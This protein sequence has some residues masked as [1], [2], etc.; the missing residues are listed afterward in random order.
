M[1]DS[2]TVNH[3]LQIKYCGETHW[4]YRRQAKCVKRHFQPGLSYRK[5]ATGRVSAGSEC[6]LEPCTPFSPMFRLWILSPST[7]V[8]HFSSTIPKFA[9]PTT[10]AALKWTP[11]SIRTGL[12]AR[13]TSMYDDN[14]VRV[15]VTIL[16]VRFV[17]F[18][19]DSLMSERFFVTVG[20][21]PSHSKH[22]NG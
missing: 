14:G 7:R 11:N 8:R 16:Q 13:I 20:E 15:P 17:F 4:S 22:Q 12:I 6:S 18:V 10:N 21:L 2:S 5:C 19:C 1:V 9:T 3:Q